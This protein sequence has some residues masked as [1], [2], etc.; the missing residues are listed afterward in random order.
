MS[1]DMSNVGIQCPECGAT[2]SKVYDSRN[3]IG[4]ERRKWRRRECSACEY[5][6]TTEEMTRDA[7]LS[8]EKRD[9]VLREILIMLLPFMYLLDDDADDQGGESKPESAPELDAAYQRGFDDD[10]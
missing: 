4:E 9:Q 6:F 7:L 5:R 3:S 8:F 2:K 1:N 10:L